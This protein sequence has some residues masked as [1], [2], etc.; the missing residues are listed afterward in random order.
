MSLNIAYFSRFKATLEAGGGC[1]RMMQILA[2]LRSTYPESRLFT[3]ADKTLLPKRTRLRLRA[4]FQRAAPSWTARFGMRLWRWSPEHRESV[5]RLWRHSQAWAKEC[6]G[7]DSLDLALIDDPV[8]FQPL[9]NLLE[10]AR[11]PVVAVCHNIESLAGEQIQRRYGHS[12]FRIETDLLARC[13]CVITISHEEDVLLRNLGVNSVYLPY[14]PVPAISD[15]LLAVRARRA[16]RQGQGVLMLGT[17]KNKQTR[18]GMRQAAAYWNDQHLQRVA[19]PLIMGGFRIE[20]FIDPS[21]FGT[22]VDFRGTLDDTAL[23]GVLAGVRAFLCHQESGSGALTRIC[24][25]LLAG[26]PVLASRHAARSYY[27]APGLIE[28][29]GL[30]DLELA[31]AALER[32]TSDFPAPSA[33]EL[34][35]VSRAL[36]AVTR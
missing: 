17:A 36:Q 15:R 21:P 25:M 30:Q 7:L 11:V 4:E 31:L 9:F 32:Q 1:R 3:M 6:P 10:A 34:Y 27:N 14:F 2:L 5:W 8:Y 35:P 22:A 29:A 19:G 13:R 12:L 28:Y 23:D 33:P 18:R 20:E 26:V 16:G 24:E